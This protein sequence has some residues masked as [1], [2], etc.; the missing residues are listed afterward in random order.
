MRAH[1]GWPL[2]ADVGGHPVYLWTSCL[3]LLTRGC[4]AVRGM[5]TQLASAKADADGWAAFQSQGNVEDCDRL[6]DVAAPIAP[7]ND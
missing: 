7:K 1:C 3:M 4:L 6:E 5:S 2:V